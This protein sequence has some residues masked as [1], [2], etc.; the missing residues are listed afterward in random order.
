MSYVDGI[1]FRQYGHDHSA[2]RDDSHVDLHPVGAVFSAE[3]D[4]VSGLYA[5]GAIECMGEGYVEGKLSVGDRLPLRIVGKGG[6]IPVLG[7]AFLV[8]LYEVE[9]FHNRY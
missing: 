4:F 7:E 8:D 1:E 2:I 3:G 6:K 9:Y 5:D